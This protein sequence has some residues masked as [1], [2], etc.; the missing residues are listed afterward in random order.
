MNQDRF[1]RAVPH[2]CTVALLVAL[3][4]LCVQCQYQSCLDLGYSEDQCWN[5]IVFQE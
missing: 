5:D 2:V 4:V 1:Y 3:I